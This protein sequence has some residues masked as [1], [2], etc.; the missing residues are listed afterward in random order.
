MHL[1]LTLLFAPMLSAGTALAQAAFVPLGTL[2]G[3]VPGRMHSNAFAVS[4]DGSVVVGRSWGNAFRWTAA[5]GMVALTRVRAP[6]TNTAL[7]CSADGSIVVGMAEAYPID[8][9]YDRQ[10][11]VWPAGSPAYALADDGYNGWLPW[12]YANGVS[13]E[14]VVVGSWH[15]LAVVWRPTGER[16]VLGDHGG[17]AIGAA[18][19]ITADGA[20]VAGGIG[21]RAYR[22]RLG[23]GSSV[24]LGLPIQ[25]RAI[26]AD[27]QTVAGQVAQF[28]VPPPWYQAFVWTPA[29]GVQLLG[30]L[31][32]STMSS[33]GL[34]LSADGRR[35][36]G[37]GS[38]VNGNEAF[39]WEIDT[40]MRNLR[41]VLIRQHGLGPALDGWRLT[42]ATGVSAD[43]S[44]IVGTGVHP[45]PDPQEAFLVRLPRCP[46]DYDRDGA[47]TPADV[48][49]FVAAW[50][51]SLAAGNDWGDFDLDDQVTPADVA[52]FVKAWYAAATGACP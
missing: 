52:A 32:G 2:P 34:A 26:A 23:D 47:F 22:W 21:A 5:T 13:N 49:A 18:L 19:A 14:G 45:F 31:P 42:E 6:L 35:V 51:D 27:G 15:D 48:V 33:D 10:G 20:F 43:G 1:R 29:Q 7:G 37:F 28:Q 4:A 39:V 24:L 12:S 25:A 46:G 38:T 8:P 9:P 30:D 11:V 44:A 17:G 40:G 50:F 36:V 41:H 16:L 3:P